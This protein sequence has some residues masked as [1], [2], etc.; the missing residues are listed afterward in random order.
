MITL[1]GMHARVDTITELI[2]PYVVA[3]ENGPGASKWRA[4]VKLLHDEIDDRWQYIADKIAAWDES[5][6]TPTDG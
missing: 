6:E 2:E 5:G 4:A 3:D 1:E